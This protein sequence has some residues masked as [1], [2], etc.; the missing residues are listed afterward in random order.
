VHRSGDGAVA[1]VIENARTEGVVPVET[2]DDKLRHYDRQ[3]D[4]HLKLSFRQLAVPEGDE[5]WWIGTLT[6]RYFS[7]T[8]GKDERDSFA[9]SLN[10]LLAP[11]AFTLSAHRYFKLRE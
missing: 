8:P 9:A 7:A 3:V 10:H 11:C 2:L 6:Q 4:P 1:D 5:V